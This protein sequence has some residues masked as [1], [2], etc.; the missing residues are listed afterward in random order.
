MG[1]LVHLFNAQAV[2]YLLIGGQAMR[3]EGLPR[4]TMD[5]DFYIPPRDL[6]SSALPADSCWRANRPPIDRK[7]NWTSSSSKRRNG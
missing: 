6:V 7:T 2:R 5:G 1:E 4:F 3:L